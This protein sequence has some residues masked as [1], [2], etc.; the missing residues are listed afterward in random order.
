MPNSPVDGERNSPHI[1]I[2]AFK[3]EIAY[4][5]VTGP[6]TPAPL[7]AD[8]A[9]HAAHLIAGL[10]AALAVSSRPLAELPAG[11]EPGVIVEVETMPLDSP[12]KKTKPVPD[13]D[14]A[15]Q[16]IRVLQTRRTDEKTEIGVIF[17]P[18]RSRD[19]LQRRIA[20]YGDAALG[21]RERL[22]KAEFESI[23]T[24]RQGS[25]DSLYVGRAAFETAQTVWWEL[26]VV[27]DGKQPV[28]V[29]ARARGIDVHPSSLEFPDIE[30]L[31]I[32][33]NTEQ[34]RV[35]AAVTYG[36]IA[37]IRRAG[38]RPSVIL[39]DGQTVGQP[40]WVEDLAARIAP[41]PPDAPAIC[42]HDTGVAAA[43]E[44]I[45]PGLSQALAYKDE[46]NTD[47]HEAFGG[48]GTPMAGLVLHGDLFF[49]CQSGVTHQ[50]THWVES[51]K[52]L[53]PPPFAANDPASYGDITQGAVAKIEIEDPLRPRV[54]CLAVT[55]DVYDPSRPSSW[56]GA[57][58]QA[59]AGTMPGDGAPL[60]RRL[61]LI[62]M[63]NVQD[64]GK[65]DEVLPLRG[66]EDPAQSW[67]ALSIGGYTAKDSVALPLKP[68]VLANNRSPYS[69][70]TVGFETGLMPFKPEV[71]FEAGNMAVN[72]SGDCMSHEDLSVISTGSLTIS[73]PLVPFWATSA[74]TGIASNFVGRLMAELPGYWPETYRALTVH[75]ADW[76][77]PMRRL[78]RAFSS[79]RVNHLL[80]REFGFGVPTLER[81]I[82]SA[83]NDVTLLAQ[84]EIQP[85]ALS[86]DGQRAVFN[87]IHYYKLPWP[88]SV[89]RELENEQVRLRITL[90]CF[91]DVN[92]SPRA[93]TRPDTYRA[94][95]LRFKLKRKDETQDDFRRR[96][97]KS[98]R[99]AGESF[100]SDRESTKWL[101][102]S[103]GHNAGSLHCDIWKG[104]A[105]DLASIDMIAVHPV[106][107][108]W[109][110]HMGQR[111]AEA[112]GRYCLLVS[113]DAREQDCDLYSE[114]TSVIASTIEQQV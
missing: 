94:Y 63:G 68:A 15:Q 51:M 113:I 49:P 11:V 30:I 87:E 6:V 16:S 18:D 32:H 31:F 111:K 34:I 109:K 90:S 65:L 25:A 95:G 24:I 3:T 91:P 79:R 105:I 41:P 70:G 47:D 75:S 112:K 35:I 20:E 21:N 27:R 23:E 67:N 42:V 13:L 60:P 5:P 50:M 19:F 33:A 52:I 101:I 71:V 85:F 106:T 40:D 74:A 44:L 77:N 45:Q 58:D 36:C 102:G 78:M 10:Q 99:G 17:V 28:I 7:R 86:E 48:H 114:I 46:W 14:F 72:A 108:W 66:L 98:E 54:H 83:R 73:K 62:S 1:D 57:I 93:A 9:A 88:V 39:E 37:E 61:F 104:P 64:K 92:L 107:G 97:N 26:W 59:A 53:P 43:H 80:L 56:S 22:H 55:D 110:T 82:R 29:A 2:A 84:S 12:R 81:A 89:L 8:Y 76:T 69:R 38:A 103:K 96:I 4:S 100:E